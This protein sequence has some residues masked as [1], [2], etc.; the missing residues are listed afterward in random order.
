MNI[1]SEISRS[2]RNVTADVFLRNVFF[3]GS[4]YIAVTE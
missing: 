4:V 2:A 1:E 3:F